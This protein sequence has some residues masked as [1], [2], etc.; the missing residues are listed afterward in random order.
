M[1]CQIK[2]IDGEQQIIFAEVYAPNIPDSQSHYMSALEIEKT[3]HNFMKNMRLKKVDSEHDFEESGNYLVESFI[4]RKGD[5]TFIPGSWVVGIKIE[6]KNQWEEIKN[7][8]FNGLS[9]AG[10]ARTA[11]T[12]ELE[13]E[14]PDL[15]KGDTHENN[16]HK[17]VFSITL[18][19]D[20]KISSGSTDIVDNHSHDIKK[21]VVTE[22]FNG[23][24]HRFSYLEVIFNENKN[25][26]N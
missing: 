6:D 12:V 21:G 2:K 3:A 5:P 11:D 10:M 22:D 9:L 15:L 8:D 14:V 18:S 16:N 24:S 7:N 1:L 17:H 25:V 20:G 19:E 13:L 26:G 4:A 23:H